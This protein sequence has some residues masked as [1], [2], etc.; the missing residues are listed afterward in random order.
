MS[1]LIT[2][3]VIAIIL[4]AFAIGYSEGYKAFLKTI[5]DVVVIPGKGG[6]GGDIIDANGN[7]I[8]KG[9]PGEL[10]SVTMDENG[11]VRIK[12]GKGGRGAHLQGVTIYSIAEEVAKRD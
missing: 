11:V 1:I 3:G 8:V 2:I 7:V 10:G 9:E 6:D 4:I 5:R 12:S